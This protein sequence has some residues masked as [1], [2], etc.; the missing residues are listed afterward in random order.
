MLH[1]CSAWLNLAQLGSAWLSSACPGL[2]WHRSKHYPSNGFSMMNLTK[3][4][5]NPESYLNFIDKIESRLQYYL[6]IKNNV[7]IQ[8]L[9][10]LQ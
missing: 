3:S 10:N 1:I 6:H 2:A 8:A 9:C 7:F 4:A 5:Y